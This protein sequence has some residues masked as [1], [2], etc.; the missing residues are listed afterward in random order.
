MANISTSVSIPEE[1]LKAL[2]DLAERRRRSRSFLI[3]EGA[4]MLLANQPKFNGNNQQP[5]PKKKAG[6]R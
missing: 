3:T 2:D 1:V 4:E 5:K 6:T